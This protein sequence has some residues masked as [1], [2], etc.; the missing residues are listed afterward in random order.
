MHRRVCRTIHTMARCQLRAAV[1]TYAHGCIPGSCLE[2][3]QSSAA[4][5]VAHTGRSLLG[6][7]HTITHIRAWRGQT[8]RTTRRSVQGLSPRGHNEWTHTHTQQ[9]VGTLTFCPGN[10][11]G[12]FGR[13]WAPT[14]PYGQCV[15]VCVSV[16]VFEGRRLWAGG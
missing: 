9:A 12:C 13:F 11:S 14:A 4:V 2:D 8:E 16:S 15:C 3:P 1:C 5:L 6:Q 7:T 10:G